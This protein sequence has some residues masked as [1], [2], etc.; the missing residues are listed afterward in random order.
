MRFLAMQSLIDPR[1]K[2]STAFYALL[3]IA[4]WDVISR[5]FNRWNAVILAALAIP[6]VLGVIGAFLGSAENKT[7]PPS[8]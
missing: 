5:G 4:G 3:G 8:G 7:P 6:G 2:Q 1:T